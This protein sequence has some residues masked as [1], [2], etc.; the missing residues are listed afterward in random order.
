MQHD[1][2]LTTLLTC[3][4]YFSWLTKILWGDEKWLTA[5]KGA[6]LLRRHRNTS[7]RAWCRCLSLYYPPSTPEV[8]RGLLVVVSISGTRHWCGCLQ[9]CY[10]LTSCDVR[11]RWGLRWWASG[12]ILDQSLFHGEPNKSAAAWRRQSPTVNGLLTPVGEVYQQSYQ[13]K[14][15]SL[16]Y[17]LSDDNRIKGFPKS[18]KAR[19]RE[20]L[21]LS[22]L[23][24]IELRSVTRQWGVDFMFP[25]C[26]VPM[27]F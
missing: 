25:Y 6:S 14:G 5:G 21:H 2:A 23:L 26:W 17:G 24:C 1:V 12:S 22:K 13:V 27:V 19:T 4:F 7:P 15:E 3:S 11:C 16:T 18:T 9:Y 20:V 10:S 8:C